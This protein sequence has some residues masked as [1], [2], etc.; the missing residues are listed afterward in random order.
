MIQAII[1]GAGAGGGFP[2][3][4]SNAP[5]C[6]RSRAGDPDAL[7]R[8]QASVAVSG[9]GQHWFILNASPDLRIQIERTPALHPNGDARSTPIAGVILTNSEV[10]SIAGLLT[11]RER[12][13]FTL[14]AHAS[15]HEQ[16]DANPI[17]E[18][19]SRA[20]VPRLR[21]VLD[22]PI[23]LMATDGEPAGLTVTAFAVAGKLPLYAEAGLPDPAALSLDG[24][25]VGL[26][27][28]DGMRRMLFVPA[29]A[30]VT[31]D[32]LSRARDADCLLFDATLWRDDEM[33]QAGL[34]SKTGRRMGHLPV[35][36][37]GGVIESF[38]G[39]MSGSRILIH[40]NNSNP[41]LLADSPERRIAEAAGWVVA[42]DGM[43]W[44]L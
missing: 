1:L 20:L 32:L 4:N 11:L 2:Q 44:Q 29:C 40:M 33:I 16:L 6:R 37:P 41:V 13:E 8:T 22:E 18:V 9:D 27:L 25:T 19:V 21:M 31:P 28:S 7:P 26:C 36:G 12:Q 38:R 5:G 15:V 14:L 24:G 17:F 30:M 10:D 34:G 3:W 42:H 39:L 23:P 43:T 35:S